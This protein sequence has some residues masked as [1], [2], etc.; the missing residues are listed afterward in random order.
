MA[1]SHTE[2]T[3][4]NLYRDP[5]PVYARLR[6]EQPVA[7]FDGT[8]EYFI[9]R[10]DDCRT[11]GGNDKIF[12]PSGSADRPEARVMGMPNVLTMSGEEHQCLRE[13]IDLNLT[14]EHVRSFVGALTRPVVAR[15]HDTIRERAKRT[16][17]PSC[18]NRSPCAASA[19]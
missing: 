1:G 12:G 8:K 19:T 13:G 2:L 11:I 4:E 17:R 7:F 15:Y 16:L 10:F 3:G 14:Q 5:Y 18:S 9:T 6:A